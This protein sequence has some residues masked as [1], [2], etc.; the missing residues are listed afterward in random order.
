MLKSYLFNAAIVFA[1]RL[2]ETYESL[3][4]ESE[5]CHKAA[6]SANNEGMQQMW[7]KKEQDL[8][9]KAREGVIK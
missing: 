8:R 4:Y 6:V 7:Y 9:L 1:V 5:L 2:P 3:M